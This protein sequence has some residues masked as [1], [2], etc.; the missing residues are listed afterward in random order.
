M[1]AS[2]STQPSENSKERMAQMVSKGPLQLLLK[3]LMGLEL[4]SAGSN[5]EFCVSDPPDSDRKILILGAAGDDQSETS[6]N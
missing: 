4:F 1:Q 2:G 3:W 6:G 5:E